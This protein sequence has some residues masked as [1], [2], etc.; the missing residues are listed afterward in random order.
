MSCHVHY[1]NPSDPSDEST[2]GNDHENAVTPE[3]IQQVRSQ[4]TLSKT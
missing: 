4:Q 3:Q 2:G 1:Y